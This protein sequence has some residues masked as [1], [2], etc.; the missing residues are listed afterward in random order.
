MRNFGVS[1]NRTTQLLD[2]LKNKKV[3][4]AIENAELVIITIG[5][6]D[7]MKVVTE[8]LTDLDFDDFEKETKLRNAFNRCYNKNADGE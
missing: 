8:N 4:S 7:V 6:N 5:G 3:Q 1:G 2:H